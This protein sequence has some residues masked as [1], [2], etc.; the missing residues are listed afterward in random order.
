M[1]AAAVLPP[2]EEAV[3]ARSPGAPTPPSPDQ[4]TLAAHRAG[5][6][7]EPRPEPTGSAL[8]SSQA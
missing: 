4:V 7:R 8:G 2:G 5:I 1:R 3:R 6:A